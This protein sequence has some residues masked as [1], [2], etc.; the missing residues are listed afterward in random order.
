[1][2][3]VSCDNDQCVLAT[4]GIQCRLNRLG[5]LHSVA[6]GS[7]GTIGMMAMVNAPSFHHQEKTL[8]IIVENIDRLGGHLGERGLTCKV[9]LTIGL[10]AHL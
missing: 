4:S 10:I 1:M 7:I 6:Q 2:A 8:F 3:V 9:I 5:Q